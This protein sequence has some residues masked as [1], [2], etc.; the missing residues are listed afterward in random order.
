MQ[1][2]TRPAGFD[3]I[4]V[5]D[6]REQRRRLIAGMNREVHVLLDTHGLVGADERPLDQ[7][8][9]LPVGIEPKLRR[10]ATAAHVIVVLGGDLGTGSARLEQPQRVGLRLF[11]LLEAVDQLVRG[12]AEHDGPRDLRV[13]AAR[14]VVLDQQREVLA[15]LQRARLLMAIDKARG[16]PERRRGAEEEALLAAEDPALV[17]RERCD[18][19][20]GHAGADLLQHASEDLVLH[21]GAL[22]DEVLLLRALD[23]LEPVDELGRV[24]ELGIAVELTLDARHELIRHGAVADPA[25]GAIAAALE[26]R[27][28]Q[29]GLVFVG[30]GDRGEGGREDHLADAAI[31]LVAA[32]E[33]APR[34]LGAHVDHGHQV[35]SREDHAARIAVREWCVGEP[36]DVTAEPIV[37]VLHHQG[38]D[39]ARGH[40][41][42]RGCPAAFEL[43]GRDRIE[44]T[45]IHRH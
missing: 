30:I 22:A 42:A 28:N 7:V 33:L 20:V 36:A 14:S 3:E 1:A 31:D 6:H 5:A 23:R 9:A 11:H 43:G 12:L 4:V 38:V 18:L 32:V 8:V 2:R 35:R 25:D 27:R 40:L 10:Q 39:S 16:L 26:L 45:F 34:A 37:V 44:Q 29:L 21:L 17:L 13:H 15:G 19:V 24:D 41:L